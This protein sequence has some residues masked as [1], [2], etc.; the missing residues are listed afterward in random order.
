MNNKPF[1]RLSC[2]CLIR[3]DEKDGGAIWIEHPFCNEEKCCIDKYAE[4][5]KTCLIC[6]KCLRCFKHEKC[7]KWYR[8]PEK[9]F[10][11]AYIKTIGLV[12]N[13]IK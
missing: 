3:C 4:K 12:L 13:L 7:N 1:I 10:N 6:G 9:I 8:I 5:H 11:F 2:G